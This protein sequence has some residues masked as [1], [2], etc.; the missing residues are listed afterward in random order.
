MT[1]RAR[2]AL[3]V[4]R[5]LATLPIV[6]RPGWNSTRNHARHVRG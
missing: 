5:V 6:C 2:K 1:G 3:G 4:T